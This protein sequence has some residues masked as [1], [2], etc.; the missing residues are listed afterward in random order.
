MSS[1]ED[2][3]DS[4]L[5][6]ALN[7]KK[8]DERA[9]KDIEPIM[10]ADDDAAHFDV[11]KKPVNI[12]SMRDIAMEELHEE[13]TKAYYEIDN[14]EVDSVETDNIKTDNFDIEDLK[15]DDFESDDIIENH[16]DEVVDSSVIDSLVNASL[17][18]ESLIDDSLIDDSMISDNKSDNY[19][20]EE[21]LDMPD[22]IG[23]DNE[24]EINPDALDINDSD[25]KIDDI[26]L[27]DISLDNMPLDDMSLDDIQLDDMPLDIPDENSTNQDSLIDAN[28][29]D[30]DSSE[31]DILTTDIL[32]EDADLKA[33]DLL[34][35]IMDDDVTEILDEPV[36]DDVLAEKALEDILGDDSYSDSF[37]D[38]IDG[39]DSSDDANIDDDD[40]FDD[41]SEEDII[42][43]LEMAESL[44]N[45]AAMAEKKIQEELADASDVTELIDS[46]D[47]N[48]I[49]IADIGEALKMNDSNEILD[50]SI[51]EDNG[52]DI[53]ALL[54]NDAD[55]S[56]N[57]EA[58][59]KKKKKKKKKG[60]FDFLKKKKKDDETEEAVE[61]A[62]EVS[63]AEN[64]LMQIGLDDISEEVPIAEVKK[65]DLENEIDNL[66]KADID[67]SAKE[68]GKDEAN[69]EPKEKKKGLLAKIIS[70]LTEEVDDEESAVPESKQTNLS[71]E[72]LAI[73]AEVDAEKDEIKDKKEKKPKKEKKKKEKKAKDKAKKPKKK[74]EKTKPVSEPGKKLP[75]PV[76][77]KTIMFA[78]SLF[79][80][81]AVIIMLLPDKMVLSDARSAFYKGDYESAFKSMYGKKL[82]ASDQK[83]YDKSKLIVLLQRKYDSY[84]NYSKM[85]MEYEALDSLIK[86]VGKYEEYYVDAEKLGMLDDFN[87]IYDQIVDALSNKYN[88]SIAEVN[89]ILTYNE[90]DYTLKLRAVLAGTPYVLKAD[91]INST[92]NP[93]ALD[94]SDGTNQSDPTEGMEDLLPEEKEYLDS[95]NNQDNSADDSVSPD[96]SNI[97]NMENIDSNEHTDSDEIPADLNEVNPVDIIIESNQ[98]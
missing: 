86:G 67:D 6:N 61:T 46:L 78:A 45:E 71:D 38:A 11:N 65:S 26:P 40:N 57:N 88:L 47:V 62:D 5:A 44:G 66:V 51:A 13:G 23:F 97:D 84:I 58:E 53:A 12:M 41:F 77:I 21:T 68:N 7:P 36:S 96:E 24:E 9:K 43:Q 69:A 52:E 18:N 33:D 92:Y 10:G 2:Y 60:L 55:E 79:A 39:M 19:S 28:I 91:E 94:N 81:L 14:V 85:N 76:V 34:S 32:E 17:D 48:D 63:D 90:L 54:G 35:L 74:K 93:G 49:D 20:G 3:L 73:L 8:K 64:E 25:L 29:P 50:N 87:S 15:V 82:S 80:A 75:K 4:L 72:N 83:L 31:G 70:A 30:T 16:E 22:I 27:D 56:D 42:R 95:I 1:S 37:A 98:F 59:G 89:E